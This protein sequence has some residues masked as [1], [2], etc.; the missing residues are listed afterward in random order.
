MPRPTRSIGTNTISG[1]VSVSSEASRT[2]VPASSES[3]PQRTIE[4]RRDRREEPRNPDR[5][6][7]QRDGQRQQARS[8]RQ[9]REAE[10]DRE[11]ERHDE[12]D[13]RLDEELEEEH[14]Q[15]A[16]QLPVTEHVRPQERLL[17]PRLAAVLPAEEDPDHEQARED[18]PHGGREVGPGRPIRLRLD[19]AP[20]ARPQHTEHDQPQP[21]GR[22]NRSDHVELR[23]LLDRRVRDPPGEQKDREHDDDLAGEDP[24]PREIRRAETADQGPD[25]DGDGACRG[26]QPVGG[27]PPFRREVPGDERDDRGHDQRRADPLQERPAEEQHGQA[28]SD[29]GRERAAAV[30]DAPDREGPLAADDGSDLGAGE[31]QR[32]HHERVGGDRALNP[33]HGR[34]HVLR[35][36]RDRD[37]HHRAVERHQELP[38]SQRQEDEHGTARPPG[39]S[40]LSS[41]YFSRAPRLRPA[42]SA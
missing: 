15:A 32:R 4:P 20:L 9:R 33:G 14:R 11:V 24:A 36:G 21:Q 35:H 23:A 39:H 16:A 30:D 13:A 29:R 12:E 28:R 34:A 27:G 38:G 26:H 25:R 10:A 22:Q 2:T 8:G 18:E 19:P 31:H 1:P 42:P 7:E 5:G 3:R 6:R 17:P 41:D 40:A 37:V